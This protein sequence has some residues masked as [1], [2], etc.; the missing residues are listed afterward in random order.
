MVCRPQ[1]IVN[2]EGNYNIAS[3]IFIIDYERENLMVF[4]KNIKK[5]LNIVVF[6]AVYG[7][8]SA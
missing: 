1:C 6:S 5:E 7:E 2:W 3:D 8:F 4:Y